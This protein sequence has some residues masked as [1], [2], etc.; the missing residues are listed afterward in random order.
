MELVTIKQVEGPLTVAYRKKRGKWYCTA[1]EFDLVGI[2]TSRTRAFHELR[3]LVNNY[4]EWMLETTGRVRFFNRSDDEEWKCA[5]KERYHVV[6]AFAEPEKAEKI[7]ERIR[8]ISSL[9]K[10]RDRIRGLELIP[11]GV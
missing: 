5:D 7:P 4:L 2:G 1:L 3:G 6:V 10:Y 8:S 11:A 9:R